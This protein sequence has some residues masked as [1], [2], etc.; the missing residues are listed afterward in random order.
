MGYLRSFRFDKIKIDQSFIK[1]A[2]EVRSHNRAIIAAIVTLADAL[3]MET[4]AEGIESLDQLALV[5]SLGA[6]HVQGFVYSK[7]VTHEELGCKLANGEWLLAANGLTSQR[8]E[9]RSMYRNAGAICRTQYQ[10]ILVR[11]LSETGA[12]VEGLIDIPVGELIAIN[13]GDGEL[14][15][16]KVRRANG[17]LTGVQFHEPMMRK[18]NDGFEA[19]TRFSGKQLAEAGLTLPPSDCDV[20]VNVNVSP[21]QLAS[22][23]GCSGEFKEWTDSSEKA[24]GQPLIGK[25]NATTV[26]DAALTYLDTRGPDNNERV[27]DDAALRRHILP[28]FGHLNRDNIDPRQVSEW[29]AETTSNGCLPRPTVDRLGR[30]LRQLNLIND[31]EIDSNT[32]ENGTETAKNKRTASFAT[33]SDSESAALSASVQKSSGRI[34]PLLSSII[35]LTGAKARD[36][37]NLDWKSVDME[38]RTLLLRDARGSAVRSLPMGEVLHQL[39]NRT[40]FEKRSGFLFVNPSTKRPYRSVSGSWETITGRAGLAGLEL[41]DL[42]FCLGEPE[43]FVQA[44]FQQS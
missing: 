32:D 26:R 3:G 42:R 4:T 11:N 33:L 14:V 10:P 30:L 28:R 2:N 7:A 13:F 19:R 17:R 41:D 37:L 36:L 29:F 1:E 8:K 6:T 18:G 35:A 9:R 12:L 22:S 15:F 38:A 25:R 34:T 24:A 31:P 40:P 5:R 21:E 27:A 20:G 16:A 44:I 39:F 23:L 43:Q